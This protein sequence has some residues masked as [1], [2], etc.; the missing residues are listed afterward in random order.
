MQNSS[1]EF[2]TNGFDA[3]ERGKFSEFQPNSEHSQRKQTI[4]FIIPAFS[5]KKSHPVFTCFYSLHAF[6]LLFAIFEL[7]MIF[8]SLF[9]DARRTNINAFLRISLCVSFSLSV[10]GPVPPLLHISLNNTNKLKVFYLQRFFLLFIHLNIVDCVP[11]LFLLCLPLL[12]C[13]KAWIFCKF[14][15]FFLLSLCA[16]MCDRRLSLVNL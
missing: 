13:S 8:L 12:L 15:Y 9:Y 14:K 3:R 10:V 16:C 7:K 1:S 6:W 4:L 2:N 5:F 11:N